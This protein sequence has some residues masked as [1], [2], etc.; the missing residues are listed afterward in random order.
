MKT[1]SRNKEDKYLALI[2]GLK[3]DPWCPIQSHTREE[4]VALYSIVA[5]Y[6]FNFDTQDG[7]SD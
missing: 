1:L 7:G 2:R 6:L 3:K 4:K 5:Q